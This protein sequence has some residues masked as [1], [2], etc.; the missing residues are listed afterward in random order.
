M[1][2]QVA[3]FSKSFTA[4]VTLERLLPRVRSLVNYKPAPSG[5]LFVAELAREL[6]R[7]SVDGFVGIEVAFGKE[8]LIASLE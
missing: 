4:N 6:L 7:L 2:L 8:S 3:S 5:I 1:C